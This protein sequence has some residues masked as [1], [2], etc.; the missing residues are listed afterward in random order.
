MNGGYRERDE[1]ERRMR[2]EYSEEVESENSEE[3][4]RKMKEKEIVDTIPTGSGAAKTEIEREIKA[5]KLATK[6][7][8]F[9]RDT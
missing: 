5:L 4:E 9:F 8:C 3:V 6:S 2:T 7:C 1:D